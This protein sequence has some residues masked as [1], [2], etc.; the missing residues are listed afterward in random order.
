MVDTL[1]RNKSI[2]VVVV[3]SVAALILQLEIDNVEVR[4]N[5]KLAQ[6]NC[7]AD[8]VTCGGNAL[9]F[10]VAVRMKLFKKALLKTRDKATGLGIC[11]KVIRNKLAP[12]MTN[13]ELTIKFRRGI[14]CESEILELACE[15][16]IIL[17]KGGSYFIEGKTL[18]T[19]EEAEDFLT[20]NSSV[21]DH[22]VKNLRCQLFERKSKPK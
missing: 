11:V 20:A 9:P 3:D 12:A 15:H 19:Q 7:P 14:C 2:A 18:N 16:G 8:Q 13:A 6:E 22:I 1:T 17:N 10:Y 21:L 5:L 4:V